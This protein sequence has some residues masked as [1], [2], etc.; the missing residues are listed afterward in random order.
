MINSKQKITTQ[1]VAEKA[2]LVVGALYRFFPNIETLK[3]AV[4][5]RTL[6]TLYQDLIIIIT[7]QSG[8]DFLSLSEYLIDSSMLFYDKHEELVRTILA[9]RYHAE[10][11]LPNKKFNRDLKNALLQIIYEKKLLTHVENVEVFLDVLMILNDS[12]CNKAWSIEN[13]NERCTYVTEWK[14]VVFGYMKSVI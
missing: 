4:I 6:D 5:T 9:T 8:N 14:T 10:F 7:E 2:G 11:E 13:K 12:L 1:L 3:E